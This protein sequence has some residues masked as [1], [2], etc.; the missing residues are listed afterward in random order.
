MHLRLVVLGV[1]RRD[2]IGSGLHAAK[3]AGR[4]LPLNAGDDPLA[5]LSGFGEGLGSGVKPVGTPR[6]MTQGSLS[7]TGNAFDLA[8]TGEGFF[9]IL[10]PDGTFSYTR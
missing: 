7:Q 8:I 5:L 1:E 10:M 3:D 6:V 4:L 9:K 2:R